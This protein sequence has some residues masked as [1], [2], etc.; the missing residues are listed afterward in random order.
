M[1][2]DQIVLLQPP[3]GFDPGQAPAGLAW[4]SA[5][6]GYE[7]AAMILAG[8][9]A[10]LVLHLPDITRDE[11]P[12]LD[13]ARRNRVAMLGA[14]GFPQ[15]LTTDDL[16]GCQLVSAGQLSAALQRLA[17]GQEGAS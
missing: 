16:D 17:P 5:A 1:N 9:A 10:A 8:Q 7:A 13:I 3:Q 2:A 15:N 14:G 4:Q 6:T 12:L 11:L